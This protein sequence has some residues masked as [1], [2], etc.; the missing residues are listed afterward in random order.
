MSK[1]DP[2]K[3]YK[4]SPE[5]IKLAVLYYVRYPLS[6]RQVE[7][8]LHERDIDVCHETVRYWWNKFG[9]LFA[10][11]MKKRP[12]HQVSNWRWHIDEVFVKINGELHYL[13]RAVDQEGTVLDCY[14]SKRR[15]KKAA[16]KVLKK[17]MS[18]HG[19]PKEIV[20]DKLPSYKAALKDMGAVNLQ[21][22]E[23]Y[24][25]NQV[26]NSHLHFRRWERGMNKFRLMRSLQKF[27][28][29]QSS[30]LN[31]FN[32]QRHLET[33]QTFKNLRQNSVDAWQNIYV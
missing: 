33:R 21:N 18:R 11:E 1:K 19:R 8:I 23:R 16:L 14:V 31:H 7:D 24:K 27:V 28:S 5:I 20:T 30:F 10:K 29:I 13:W 2:F 9:C 4:T 22:T 3:Y 25:N 15:N 32:H 12:N 6:L 26:E 17:L